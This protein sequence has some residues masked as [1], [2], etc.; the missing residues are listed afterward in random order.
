MSDTEP[1]PKAYEPVQPYCACGSYLSLMPRREVGFTG[2]AYIPTLER[3][4]WRCHVC[5]LT[6]WAPRWRLL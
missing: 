2:P 4:E 5:D 3:M 1:T 6:V